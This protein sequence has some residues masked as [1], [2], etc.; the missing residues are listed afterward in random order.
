VREV[1]GRPGEFTSVVHLLPHCELD[2][3]RGA[4]TLRFPMQAD[5]S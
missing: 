3:L 2:E 4:V 1:P 5:V